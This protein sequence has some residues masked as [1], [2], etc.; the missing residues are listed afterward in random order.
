[1]K[2]IRLRKLMHVS[3]ELAVR[4]WRHGLTPGSVPALAFA[5]ACVVAAALTRHLLGLIDPAI[6]VFAPYFPAALVATLIAGLSSGVITLLLGAVSAWW[7]FIPPSHA[8]FPLT[9]DHAISLV[10][11]CAAGAL[12]IIAAESHRRLLRRHYEREHFDQLI[13]GEL[14][15]RLRNKSATVQAVLRQQLHNDDELWRAVAGRL[16]A[17]A[18]TDELM[19]R[20]GGKGI[21]IADIV[22]S[23]L[24]PYGLAARIRLAGD[25]V[26]V[27][28]T[29]ALSLMLVVHELS[30]NA[31][32][33]GALSTPQARVDVDWRC[34]NGRVQILWRESGG[35]PVRKPSHKGFGLELFRQALM[36]FHG[37]VEP[38]FA[39]DGFTCRVSFALLR[40]RRPLG[41]ARRSLVPP[42][43]N[44]S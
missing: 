12:I 28:S 30:T 19:L 33:Y 31:A 40:E 6:I 27:P 35:P 32:K 43:G 20:S 5:V 13:I 16:A 23:E 15:H 37:T 14:Q 11:Y 34:E 39:P 24:E 8:F 1:M 36:P 26:I 29:V 4:M 42:T 18:R 3:E 21:A 44:L 10:I 7:S 9:Q 22:R 38:D 17:I 41:Q 2:K 25:A